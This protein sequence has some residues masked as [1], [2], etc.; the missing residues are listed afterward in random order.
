[1]LGDAAI[2]TAT[3]ILGA[4]LLGG[5]KGTSTPLW[6]IVGIILVRYIFLPLLGV[7]IVKGQ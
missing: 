3:L 7:V 6:T 1:M 4:N 2:P 5:L